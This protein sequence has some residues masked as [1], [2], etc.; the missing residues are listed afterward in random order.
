MPRNCTLFRR[1]GVGVT[2]VAEALGWK[3]DSVYLAGVGQH[4]EELNVMQEVW[5]EGI[6]IVGFEPHPDIIKGLKDKF[7]GELYAAALGDYCGKAFLYTKKKHKDGSSLYP[8]IDNGK[9]EVYGKVEV[10]VVTLD[11]LFDRH[12]IGKHVLLWLDCE[13]N[14]LKVLRGGRGFI[15][16][17]EMVNVEMTASAAGVGW[18]KP[19]EVHGWLVE[20]G[21]LRQWVHTH[22]IHSGQCDCVYV[23]EHLWKQERCCDPYPI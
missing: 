8:H 16:S 9:G 4:Y 18:C 10:P 21:F 11:S 1:G 13:G 3:A 20:H 15:N 23:R 14:E 5:G 2:Q 19:E 17:V 12:T 6:S 7:P 22:R